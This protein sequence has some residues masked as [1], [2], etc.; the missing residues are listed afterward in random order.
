MSHHRGVTQYGDNVDLLAPPAYDGRSVNRRAKV[1]TL[2]PGMAQIPENSLPNGGRVAPKGIFNASIIT[3]PSGVQYWSGTNSSGDHPRIAPITSAPRPGMVFLPNATKMGLPN[4]GGWVEKSIADAYTKQYNDKAAK[5][6]TFGAGLKGFLPFVAAG[7]AIYATAGA[8]AAAMGSAG[9]AAA[10]GDAAAAGAAGSAAGATVTDV[11]AA[12]SSAAAGS[13]VDLGTAASAADAATALSLAPPIAAAAA[14]I[15]EG[16]AAGS[17]VTI[18]SGMAG[19]G[20]VAPVASSIMSG[21]TTAAPSIASA[22]APAA[23]A[24]SSF[25][26]ALSGAAKTI[27]TVGSVVTAGA[28]IDKAISGSNG[29]SSAIATKTQATTPTPA[30]TPAAATPNPA[31]QVN[32]ALSQIPALQVPNL[33]IPAPTSQPSVAPA[34]KNGP[35]WFTMAGLAAMAFMVWKGSH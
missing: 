33:N 16:G 24:G 21:T 27:T 26:S 19:A 23:S 3:S 31:E 7:L 11:T 18:T 28:A 9:G 14:P 13:V 32:Q 2:R 25:L 15:V 8:A 29:G 35:D 34:T 6:G 4:S 17:G 22:A 30:P 1:V 12:T 10:A 20:A 5:A